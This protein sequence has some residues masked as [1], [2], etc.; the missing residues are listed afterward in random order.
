MGLRLFQS[1]GIPWDE[2]F[3]RTIGGVTYKHIGNLLDLSLTDHQIANFPPLDAFKDRDYG[4]LF[5]APAFG[6][7]RYLKLNDSREQFLLR[8]LLVYIFSIFGMIGIY[9]LASRR[10]QNWKI[11]LL[12]ALF[13]FLSPRFFAESFYNSKDIVFMAIY[14]MAINTMLQ[15]SLSPTKKTA[16]IHGIF[17]AFAID[18]RILGILIPIGTLILVI[19]RTLKHEISF[20][21]ILFP[22]ILYFF[23][24]CVFSILFFP[25]LWKSPI[26]NFSLVISN[27]AHF[28]WNN[29]VLYLGQYIRA[30][31]LP[32]H[33]I[34]VWIA[35]STPVYLLVL[36]CIGMPSIL[37]TTIKNRFQLWSNEQQMQDIVL[38]A[39]FIFPIA[40]VIALKSVI[41]DGWRHLYFVY[42]A[43]L[44]ICIR[45]WTLVESSLFDGKLRKM[46]YWLLTFCILG[47][48]I[49]WIRV[50]HPYQFSYFNLL[51]GKEVRYQFDVDYW[52]VGNRRALEHLLELDS[53]PQIRIYP[54]S[55]T[56]L[57]YSF[58]M[59]SENIRYRISLAKSIE[60]SDYI[61]T[62]YRNAS[63]DQDQE[64]TKLYPISYQIKVDSQPIISIY[65][66][67]KIK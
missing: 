39:L 19:L 36:F 42:P 29:E 59:L 49:N 22:V 3:Q 15:F 8:H 23:M 31:N 4:V 7:E 33:Y 61:L 16:L 35:I 38:L 45:G 11:G 66:N 60:E 5:E 53:R 58:M 30:T 1:Y 28:R 6:L 41:Y 65:K 24:M 17:S 43:F 10:Y 26:G 62:N 40:M 18:I 56:M 2:P 44:L 32:W 34:F 12:T 63:P 54:A 37:L 50:N 27:M 20:K 64:L 48:Y 52:G 51:A 57:E 13:L 21:K 55:N 46:L 47:Y 14:T 25:Y 67:I 9:L